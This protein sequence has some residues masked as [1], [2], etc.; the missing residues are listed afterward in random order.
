MAPRLALA[1]DCFDF[2]WN[3]RKF[4]IA[5]AARMPMI[6]T[7]IIS[8]IRVNPFLLRSL[9]NMLVSSFRVW[10]ATLL[11]TLI[12]RGGPKLQENFRNLSFDPVLLQPVPQRPEGNIQ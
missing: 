3:L 8:S 7:T 2:A 9:L 4:G 10:K 5:M 12:A 6:A 1:S 11:A